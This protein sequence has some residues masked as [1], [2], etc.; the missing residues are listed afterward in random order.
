MHI[1]SFNHT[2]SFR[3]IFFPCVCGRQCAPPCIIWLFPLN[4]LLRADTCTCTR[5]PKLDPGSALANAPIKSQGSVSRISD[6]SMLV[7]SSDRELADTSA[8]AGGISRVDRAASKKKTKEV[9]RLFLTS[10]DFYFHPYVSDL[11]MRKN[12][13][14]DPERNQ[15]PSWVPVL[16]ILMS[17]TS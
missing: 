16:H 7:S 9:C 11:P 10:I 17:F 2:F 4:K 5:F 8:A 1:P 14:L 3:I 6:P 12:S 15:A 13:H